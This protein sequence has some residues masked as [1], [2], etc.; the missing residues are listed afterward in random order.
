MSGAES[1]GDE[2]DSLGSLA[3]LQG[4]KAVIATLWNV[5]DQSTQTLMREFYGI[6]E[7]HP[8]MPKAEALRQAQVA[9]LKG[10]SRYNHPYYWAPFI[11]IGNWK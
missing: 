4:A 6:R 2:V 11:L 7:T 8:G 1:D 9:L 10:E 5:E 3:Q